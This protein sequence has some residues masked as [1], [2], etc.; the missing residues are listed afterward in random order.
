MQN[1]D[2]NFDN[3]GANFTMKLSNLAD[4]CH[5]GMMLK[6]NDSDRAVT[7]VIQGIGQPSGVQRTRHRLLPT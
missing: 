2:A 7:E 6:G 5:M 4:H 1:F 3:S